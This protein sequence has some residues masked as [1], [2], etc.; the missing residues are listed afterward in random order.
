MRERAFRICHTLRRTTERLYV[1]DLEAGG[2]WVK[3]HA[4]PGTLGYAPDVRI[5]RPGGGMTERWNITVCVNVP[6]KLG[7]YTLSIYYS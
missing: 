4:L 6:P 3:F 5:I 1:Y 2:E 7:V